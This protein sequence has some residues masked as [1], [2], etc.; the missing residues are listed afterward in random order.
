MEKK[1][2]FKFAYFLSTLLLKNRHKICLFF[3]TSFLIFESRSSNKNESLRIILII[4]DKLGWI[5][6]ERVIKY[7]NGINKKHHLSK[8]R[9]I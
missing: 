6:N 4:K 8:W 2:I 3:F 1:I 9:A 7:T 5:L